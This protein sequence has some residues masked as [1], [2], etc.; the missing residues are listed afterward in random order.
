MLRVGDAAADQAD[1]GTFYA[2]YTGESYGVDEGL[3]GVAEIKPGQEIHPPHQHPD[4]EYLMVLE[5]NG[6]WYYEVEGVGTTMPARAGDVLYSAPW[7]MHGIKNTGTETLRFVVFKW[8][9][10]GLPRPV[11]PAMAKS[12]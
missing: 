10:P 9:T 8:T 6:E 1:W 11:A 7:D 12:Q 2:Y 4:E 3:F 5:G